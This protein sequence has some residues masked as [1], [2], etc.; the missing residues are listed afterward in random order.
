[1]TTTD[2][3][4]RTP[5][6]V[7]RSAGQQVED[8]VHHDDDESVPPASYRDH[9]ASRT[10]PRKRDGF[11]AHSTRSAENLRFLSSA[12]DG[13]RLMTKQRAHGPVDR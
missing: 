8:P 13:E 3:T 6:V 2:R 1:M 5:C 12:E 10:C 7:W 4:T 11:L 9:C